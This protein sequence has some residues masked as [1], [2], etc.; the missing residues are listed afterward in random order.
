MLFSSI[1]IREVSVKYIID[2]R[3]YSIITLHKKSQ[4]IQCPLI[5]ECL[6]ILMLAF[7]S[8]VRLLPV[9]ENPTKIVFPL[10]IHKTKVNMNKE[11]VSLRDL[12]VS[13]I[14]E[15]KSLVKEVKSIQANLDVSEHLPIPPIPQLHPDEVPEKI[16]ECSSDVLL[17][18]KEEQE[19]KEKLEERL[20]GC[21]SS[22]AFRHVFLQTPPV[23]EGDAMVQAGDASAVV[24]GKQKAFEMEKVE[25]TEM[26]LEILK[27]EKI[28]NLYLQETLIKKV[29]N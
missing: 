10:Q 17:K 22:R 11:I 2:N 6:I 29:G 9:E 26:E 15:I 23:E 18:F 25:P 4:L 28:K 5:T 16:V 7:L 24:T 14:D 21:P 27:R 19:A 12:K 8:W 13:T 3:S 1:K 20:E